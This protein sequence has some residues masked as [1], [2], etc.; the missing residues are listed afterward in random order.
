MTV[1]SPSF[2]MSQALAEWGWGAAY[3]GDLMR[4]L[5]RGG[6]VSQFA[7][8]SSYTPMSVYV[9]GGDQSTPGSAV[10]WTVYVHPSNGTGSYTNYAWNYS[11][12]SG[13]FNTAS[14]VG[15]GN[16]YNYATFYVDVGWD[17]SCTFAYNCTVTDSSGASVISDTPNITIY[18]TYD[19]GF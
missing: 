3:I 15:G 4:A 6:Y 10:E 18:S 14:I 2:W 9:D 17:G 11:V 13:G 12:T 1:P 16:G 19:P 8:V 7:G 5:G